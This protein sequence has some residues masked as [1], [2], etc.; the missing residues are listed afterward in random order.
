MVGS[1]PF[2][3][4][5]SNCFLLFSQWKPKLES[6]VDVAADCFK[7]T[8]KTHQKGGRVIRSID[9]WRLRLVWRFIC[10]VNV[11]YLFSARW[12]SD[13]LIT[14]RPYRHN[15]LACSSFYSSHVHGSVRIRR[16]L[17]VTLYVL[18]ILVLLRSFYLLKNCHLGRI[19]RKHTFLTH[20]KPENF[21][22]YCL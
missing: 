17:A 12:A 20:L 13:H 1:Q 16:N 14:W 6:L 8:T 22:L 11:L 2:L 9:W 5:T 3:G 10:S 18:E 21:S 4:L 19:I 7:H 15:K